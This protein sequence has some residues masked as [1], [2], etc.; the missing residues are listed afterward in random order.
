MSIT[1]ITGLASGL[2]VDA[3]VKNSMM[4]YTT[5]VDTA[6]Q[7]QEILEIKQ[8]LYRDV[9]KDGNDFFNKYFD[10]LKDDSLLR[11]KSYSTISFDP[12]NSS[13]ATATGL[14]GAVKDNYEIEVSSL[15][16]A[17][18]KTF[19][20][21]D[22][23]GGNITIDYVNGQTVT[24][25]STEFAG[26]TTDQDRAKVISAKLSAVGLKAS[27]SDFAA[28]I[29]IESK[30][31]G[32]K[33]GEVQNSFKVT[34]GLNPAIDSDPGTN[35]K[36]TVTNSKGTITYSDTVS[37]GVKV[38]GS[39]TV[40]LDGVQFNFTDTTGDPSVPIKLIGKTDVTALKDKLVSFVN[41]YNTYIEK[42]NT[43]VMDTRDRS[44][45]PL[46]SEQ[47]EAMSE[48][49]IKLW[50][51]KVEKGQLSRDND[52]SR[53]VNSLKSA[54]STTVGGAGAVLEKI[55]IIPVRDY[56]STKKGTF[57]IDEGMLTAALEEKPDEVMN[58]FIK[59][60]PSDD[61]L[62]DTDK[63]S[64]TGIFNRMRDVL[65]SEIK[66]STSSNIIKRAGIE[67]TAS[68]TQNTLSKS[69]ADHKTKITAM[70]KLL[71]TREQDL[72]TKYAK[73][74]VIMN[75]Y[76]TQQSSLASQLGT[77]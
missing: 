60:K 2:D 38:S 66:S 37:S 1:R 14:A 24:I 26:L 4:T 11:S 40:T 58:L 21:A 39:N 49:E 35:L 17:S 52:L 9:L 3:V 64:Q 34:V 44:Y 42:L 33:I 22:L 36:A 15:A 59:A 65:N 25:D 54:M 32:A 47:K 57:T 6:K 70:Q 8:K 75:K 45:I 67:G 53:I 72:Y 30:T 16:S 51:E 74:E 20:W 46:T 5:K 50:N 55:G 68:F 76:N 29:V 43:L 7:K 12:S 61:T 28:G 73:L 10:I 41:D 13:I 63:F 23:S 18:K 71:A 62:N 27:A 69:I 77:S 19:S 48:S 31:T 56:Q